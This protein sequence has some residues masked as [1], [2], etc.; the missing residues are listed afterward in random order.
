[1]LLED[2]HEPICTRLIFTSML[3][4]MAP[5]RDPFPHRPAS[6]PL[7]PAPSAIQTHRDRDATAGSKPEPQAGYTLEITLGTTRCLPKTRGLRERSIPRNAGVRR[8]LSC[9]LIAEPETELDV[10][11]AGA[12]PKLRHRL[13]RHVHLE[14]RVRDETLRDEQVVGEPQSS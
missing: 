1:M 13:D 8:E 6:P 12:D 7:T 14:A 5:T 2:G 10:I 4:S 9:D 11:E 3:G